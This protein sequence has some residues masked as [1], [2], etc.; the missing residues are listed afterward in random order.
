MTR[1]AINKALE[2]LRIKIMDEP[3]IA[4]RPA[5][6]LTCD[7]LEPVLVRLT[8]ANPGCPDEVA[9]AVKDIKAS[10][11]NTL[12]SIAMTITNGDPE[13]AM[14]LIT[15][16]LDGL[17]DGMPGALASPSLTTGETTH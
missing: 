13:A 4:R 12:A 8:Q 2:G 17:R 11:G 9:A 10:I 3:D 5:M 1:D 14:E 7:V 15:H 16:L 6:Q